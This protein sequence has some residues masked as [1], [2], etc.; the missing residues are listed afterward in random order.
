MVP[1]SPNQEE[2]AEHRVKKLYSEKRR[3]FTVESHL[4]KW[5]QESKKEK[6]METEGE[7]KKKINVKIAQIQRKILKLSKKSIFNISFHTSIKC[8]FRSLL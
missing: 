4:Q 6:Q 1:W 5:S 7:K 2:D 8:H 3:G